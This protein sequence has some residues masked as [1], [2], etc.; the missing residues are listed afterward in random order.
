MTL[1]PDFMAFNV[2]VQAMD[3][4]DNVVDTAWVEGLG[5]RP[6]C[7]L[8]ASSWLSHGQPGLP[9]PGHRGPSAALWR[10]RGR[11]SDGLGTMAPGTLAR[12][13]MRYEKGGQPVNQQT[14]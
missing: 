14:S 2:F 6:H 9:G 4:E 10:P 11:L 7:R 8:S 5:R 1:L 3:V 12:I 13:C